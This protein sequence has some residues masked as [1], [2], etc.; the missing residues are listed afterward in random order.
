MESC[1]VVLGSPRASE[2]KILGW[3]EWK[4]SAKCR[5]CGVRFE[6]TMVGTLDQAEAWSP[7][8]SPCW[9]RGETDDFM[10]WSIDG[11]DSFPE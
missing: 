1:R 7:L 4:G 2:L 8:C 11:G 10:F 9:E 6:T 5:L 3:H